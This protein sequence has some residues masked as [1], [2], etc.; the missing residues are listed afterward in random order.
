MQAPTTIAAAGGITR[1][2]RRVRGVI[3]HEGGLRAMKNHRHPSWSVEEQE[4]REQGVWIARLV[5]SVLAAG[6]NG[7][8][9]GLACLLAG[10]V[11]TLA[12]L[13]RPALRHQPAPVAAPVAIASAASESELRMVREELASLRRH[14]AEMEA[15]QRAEALATEEARARTVRQ[16]EEERERRLQ[17]EA[18]RDRALEERA[19]V[20]APV[21][22]AWPAPPP[23]VTPADMQTLL[24]Q[25]LLQRMPVPVP[26]PMP[27][28]VSIEPWPDG[29][30]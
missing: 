10:C 7:F 27:M 20:P 22:M 2:G 24:T 9:M 6:W 18:E 3:R 19:A 13:H 17:A 14:A 11:A 1:Q 4:S 15:R 12:V 16:L 29:S 5:S 28:P 25:Q 8:W 30:P 23:V 26:M 21:V